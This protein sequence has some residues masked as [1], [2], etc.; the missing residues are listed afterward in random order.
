MS[1][2]AAAC[3]RVERTPEADAGTKHLQVTADAGTP[4]D[5]SGTSEVPPPTTPIVIASHQ[6]TPQALAADDRNVYWVNLGMATGGGKAPGPYVGGSIM[7]CA[8]N[9]CDDMPE[10]LVTDR[11]RSPAFILPGTL[12]SDGQ[13]LYWSDSEI[14]RCAIDGCS[15]SLTVIPPAADTTAR[16]LLVTGGRIDWTQT[17]D[18]VFG[19][20]VT[21]CGAQPTIISSGGQDVVFANGIATDGT[22]LYWSAQG[23]DMLLMCPLEGCNDAPVALL[24]VALGSQVNLVY[25][26]AVDANNIYLA[27]SL[28]LKMGKIWSCP[29]SDCSAGITVLASGLDQPT[30]IATDG[31][32]VYW[33]EIG[34]DDG[35]QREGLGLVRKCAVTGCDNQPTTIAD[36]LGFP[37]DLVLHGERLYWSEYNQDGDGRVWMVGK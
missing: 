36:G 30:S 10:A 19:C 18:M 35:L 28:P 5:P 16:S 27:D 26:L 32:N 15:Q 22:N 33:N 34:T 20:P 3:A 31:T 23:P 14:V 4:L 17:E 12:A 9:G 6:H 25:D 11:S 29:K 1:V 37:G 13:Y 2:S 24:G 7:R 8:A 21:G